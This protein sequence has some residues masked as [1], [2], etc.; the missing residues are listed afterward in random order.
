[1]SKHTSGP[2]ASTLRRT[3]VVLVLTVA[4]AGAVAVGQATDGARVYEEQLRTQMDQQ[5]PQL[6]E[7]TFDFGG[8]LNFAWF[9]FDDAAGDDHTLR[10]YELRTWTSLNVRG[11]HKFFVRGLAA[12]DDYN[13]GDNPDTYHDDTNEQTIERAWYEFDLGRMLQNQ[14]G[15]KPLVAPRVKVGRAF[16]Q[17]GSALVLSMPLDMVEVSTDVG[18]WEF[19]ALLGKTIDDTPNIDISQPVATHQERCFWGFEMAYAGFSRH[20]PYVYFLG[21]EDH[22]S[23]NRA[24]L[25]QLGISQDFDYSSRYVGTGSR[26]TLLSPNLRYLAE[27]VGE[28]GRTY[29]DGVVS[30]QDAIC[31][32]ATDLQL[33]YLFDVKTKPKL[34]VE[35]LFATGDSDRV[36]SSTSTIGGNRPGTTDHAFN[37]FGF[38]DTGI[39]FAPQISNLHIYV[40]GASF[41]P[42]EK[43]KVFDKLELGTKTFFY[44]KDESGGPISDSSAENDAAWVGW[45]WDAYVNWRITSDL[46]WTARYGA[47]RPGEAFEDQECR[48]FVFTGVTISF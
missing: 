34:M 21:N 12:W 1:M 5:P 13:S 3:W 14:T 46:T 36:I 8:W 18:D 26:G 23:P 47:F 44:Q 4:A 15:S 27:V 38:R 6:S 19:K 9:H 29:S 16:A 11:E 35:H 32:M 33:E 41:F 37:A 30:G 7:V 40:A 20:R 43:H 22:T 10:Q 31:A 45:E 42:L 48:Q 28:F 17:I 2:R 24:D 25:N 39:A